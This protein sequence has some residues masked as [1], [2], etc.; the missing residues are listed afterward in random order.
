[1]TTADT[2]PKYFDKAE[3]ESFNKSH[4]KVDPEVYSV[5]GTTLSMLNGNDTSDGS[6]Y[7]TRVIEATIVGSAEDLQPNL[8]VLG[9]NSSNLRTFQSFY[10]SG[11]ASDPQ[12][13]PEGW[14][15][16]VY[17]PQTAFQ[18]EPFFTTSLVVG[19]NTGIFKALAL[20]I[21]T[22]LQCQD[23]K[24][25]EFLANCNETAPLAMN[26]TNTQLQGVA[27]E[28]ASDPYYIA[29]IF[30]F[31]ICSPEVRNWTQDNDNSQSIQEELFMDL[32]TWWTSP[33]I[34]SWGAPPDIP[35]RYNFTYHCTADSNLA[36][37]EP[38]NEWN[39]HH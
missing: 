27:D 36:Y 32:Q 7:Q 9:K 8:W 1:M 6:L 25:D 11:I 20:R 18:A 16:P 38:M 37:F 17:G 35:I 31:H 19:A 13:T 14:S 2:D 23:I 10:S 30:S 15:G 4:H 34:A 33:D 29:P 5:I 26:F 3:F 28:S 24:R 22:S 12:N 21:G 39:G